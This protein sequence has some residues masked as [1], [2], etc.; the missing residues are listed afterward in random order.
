MAAQLQATDSVDL[1]TAQCLPG[2]TIKEGVTLDVTHSTASRAQTITSV[3]LQKLWNTIVT[4]SE[5]QFEFVQCVWLC[6]YMSTVFI[7]PVMCV[8]GLRP[9]LSEQGGSCS[10]QLV[11]DQKL[12]VRMYPG[13]VELP[14]GLEAQEQAYTFNKAL[15]TVPTQIH[16]QQITWQ[17]SNQY[18][19]TCLD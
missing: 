19:Y 16:Y 18:T 8:M 11:W 10:T 14:Q 3:K 9:Y 6:V 1:L 2:D 4:H 15:I 17:H 5:S 12:G 13:W 7:L